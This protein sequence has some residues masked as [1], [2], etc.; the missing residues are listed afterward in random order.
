MRTNIIIND[1]LMREAMDLAKINTKKKVVELALTEFVQKR[2]HKNLNKLR[3]KINFSDNYD[4]KKTR[5]K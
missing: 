2:K 4:Y 5:S 3:D 1:E